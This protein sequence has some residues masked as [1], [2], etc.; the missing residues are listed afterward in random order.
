MIPVTQKRTYTVYQARRPRRSVAR[1]RP[2]AVDL[3]AALAGL[4][5]GVAIALGLTTVS[6]SSL[7]APGGLLTALGRIAG[8]VGTYLL[9]IALLFVGRVPA[10]ERV[11][12][13]DRLVRWHRRLGPWI[14]ILLI[15]HVVLITLGYAKGVKT[16]TLHEFTVLVGS[17]PGMLAATV[18]LGLL[19][20]AGVTSYSLARRRLKYETW[21]AVHLYT[22]L[23][24]ALAFSHQLATGVPFS[25]QPWARTYWTALWLLTA[26]L[27]LVYRCGLPL[28]RSL[29]HRLVVVAVREEGP[30][31]ISIVCRGR[32]LDRLPVLGGQFFQWRFLTRGM[33][34]QAHPYSLSALP[35]ATHLRITVKALGDHSASLSRLRLGTR[36][37]IEGPYG[38]MTRHA[39]DTDHVLLVGAGVGATPLRAMLDDLPS[40]VDVAVILRASNAHELVLRDEIAEL[41]GRRGGRLHEIIGPRSLAPL[42]A[43]AL[44]RLVPDIARRDLYICGPQGFT[45]GLLRA[46]RSLG[47]PKRRVHYEDFAF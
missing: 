4:G 23:A 29:R 46:A 5:F 21:W 27:V 22:Y 44:H 12:G 41:V 43:R 45:R 38:V 47:M 24:V 39:R 16:G 18:G 34:W 10:V 25:G 37:A 8:L 40:Q 7:A 20:V 30:G 11:I 19:L 33:W 15:A 14:V 3:C 9:L 17:F 35:T 42:D 31:V 1:P 2:S 36:V 6:A 26:G 32:R 28:A 13:Q